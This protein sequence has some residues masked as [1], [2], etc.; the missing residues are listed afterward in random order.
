MNR[1]AVSSGSHGRS[2]GTVLRSTNQCH[3]ALPHLLRL[4]EQCLLPVSTLV[5]TY[6]CELRR[7]A[8]L[9]KRDHPVGPVS[10]YDST[11]APELLVLR[12]NL[13]RILVAWSMRAIL[14]PSS[15]L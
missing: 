7:R 15:A 12:R 10:Y 1:Q 5:S 3:T 11:Y 14:R 6:L 9:S 4:E 13:V 2:H 8:L